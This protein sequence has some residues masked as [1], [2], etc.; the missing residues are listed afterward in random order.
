VILDEIKF[1]PMFFYTLTFHQTF[2]YQNW[3]GSV[4]VPA[5]VQYA[6]KLCSEKSY[7]NDTGVPEYF[8][9]QKYYI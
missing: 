2:N 3:M 7:T 6:H 8:R 5:C 1:D 9:E 4:K